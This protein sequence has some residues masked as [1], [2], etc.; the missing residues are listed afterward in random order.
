MRGDAAHERELERSHSRLR[1]FAAGPVEEPTRA[2]YEERDV[3]AAVNRELPPRRCR[4]VRVLRPSAGR[5]VRD[6]GY[7]IELDSEFVLGVSV[8]VPVLPA[9]QHHATARA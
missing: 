1:C 2:V 7:G 9:L 3:V 4:A 5:V 8:L 6:A